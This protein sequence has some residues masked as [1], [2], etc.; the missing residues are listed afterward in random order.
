MTKAQMRELLLNPSPGE[1][2][3]QEAFR[4]SQ[5]TVNRQEELLKECRTVLS[6]LLKTL[7]SPNIREDYI[8]LQGEN[9]ARALLERLRQDSPQREE[10][11]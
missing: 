9:E 7:D 6:E 8:F 1:V 11:P 2:L 3:A 5:E 10:K 4:L